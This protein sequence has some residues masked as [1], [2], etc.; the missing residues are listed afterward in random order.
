MHREYLMIKDFFFIIHMHL[1]CK[2]KNESNSIIIFRSTE[3]LLF[4]VCFIIG[5]QRNRNTK[6]GQDFCSLCFNRIQV[7][8]SL[9]LYLTKYYTN[10]AFSKIKKAETTIANSKVNYNRAW[11]TTM[12]ELKKNMSFVYFSFIKKYA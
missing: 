7:I 1:H 3:I 8:F 10:L 6:T 5:C 4:R 12:V 9:F 2:K 11:K